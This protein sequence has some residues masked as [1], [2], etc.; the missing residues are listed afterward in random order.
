[1]ISLRVLSTLAVM[2]A[3]RDLT[4]QYERETG[5][6]VEADFAPTVA[7][8][9]RLRA[10]E[11]IDIA[12]L[13]AQGIDDLTRDG[14][15]RPGTRSDVALSFVGIAI[16]AGARSAVASLWFIND[17]ATSRIVTQFYQNLQKPG[18]SKA[19]ALQQAQL[20]LMQ[21]RRFRHPGYWSPFLV[22]G[23]WL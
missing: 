8:L 22:I 13:T 1:M 20:A 16:K 18:V 10:H 11:A 17:E 7:L 14:V 3:M 21:D 4:A 19:Q 9:D 12:I 5:T 2:G 23:N 6:P 15:I